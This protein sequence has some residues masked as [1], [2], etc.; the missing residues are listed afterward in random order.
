MNLVERVKGILLQPK[1]EWPAIGREPGNAGYLF[2]NYVAIVAAIPPVCA[3]IGGSIIGQGGY[4]IGIGA[5]ILAALLTYVLEFVGVF[6]VAYV[7]DFLAGTFGAQKNF[8]NAMRVS[9]YTPTAAWVAGV[10]NLIPVLAF[11]S[12]LGLYSVYL[13]YTGIDSLMK[14][15]A[16][17]A[18]VYTI[19]VIVCA[20]IVWIIILIIPA[21]L[22]G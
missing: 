18:L 19:A 16:D 20:I 17:K 2:P 13:L 9:A 3:L 8:D 14:P 11:L 15:A 6:V 10:F 4:R 22:L 1:A 7:I 21:M 12:I 5:G